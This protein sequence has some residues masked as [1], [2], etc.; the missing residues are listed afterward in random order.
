MTDDNRVAALTDLIELRV[1]VPAALAALRP[2]PWDS[3]ELVTVTRAHLA[4]VLA[5]FADGSI[6]APEVVA[7]AESVHLRDDIAREEGAEDTVNEVLIEMSSPELF[8]DL[9]EIAPAL[10]KRLR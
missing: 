1:P 2:F 10:L 7:W 4:A 9:P 8:G 5:Q 6:S 3:D